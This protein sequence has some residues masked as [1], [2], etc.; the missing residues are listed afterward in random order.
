MTD[1]ERESFNFESASKI[2]VNDG[3]IK[4]IWL[5]NVEYMRT[6]ERK[7]EWVDL[8]VGGDAVIEFENGKKMYISNS[9][10]CSVCWE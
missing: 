7:D 5:Q 2:E 3:F 1:E 9:E 4:C 10:W 6:P 8:A